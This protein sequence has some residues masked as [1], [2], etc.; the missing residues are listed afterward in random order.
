M[1]TVINKKS[2]V[3]EIV[4]SYYDKSIPFDK[5]ELDQVIEDLDNPIYS[6]FLINPKIFT[7]NENYIVASTDIDN[8][9]CNIASIEGVKTLLSSS[10]RNELK[11]VLDTSIPRFPSNPDS[12]YVSVFIA[13]YPNVPI[14]FEIN[15]SEFNAEK[16]V[17]SMS[18]FN[19]ITDIIFSTM[20]DYEFL[21]AVIYD[22]ELVSME[23]ST[24]TE[25]DGVEFF[26]YDTK[27]EMRVFEKSWALVASTHP[28]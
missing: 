3:H 16:L 8:L 11:T 6:N 5:I 13:T 9:E 14:T 10:V 17:C 15:D 25:L 7:G 27:T 21:N 12:R 1:K 18:S 24:Q 19:S 26:I 4:M 2:T 22:G 20:D 23:M 28:F